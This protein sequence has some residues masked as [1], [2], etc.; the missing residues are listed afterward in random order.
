MRRA[1]R[2]VGDREGLIAIIEDA[3][4]CRLAFASGDT[5]YIVTMNFGYEWEGR[6]PAFYF[7]CAREGRKLEMMRSNPRVCFELDCGHALRTGPAPCNW[8]MSYSSLVGYGILSELTVEAERRAG[9]DR[10]MRHYGW[11]GEGGYSPSTLAATTV[12]RLS[13]D[14]M[15]GKRKV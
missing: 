14:E 2:A 6:L 10:V 4:A 9:L 1:D 13:V 12:L 7:H 15:S 5:P 8:G 3:D 11:G